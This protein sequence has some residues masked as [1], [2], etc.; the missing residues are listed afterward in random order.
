LRRLTD[1]GGHARIAGVSAPADPR[2]DGTARP[3]LRTCGGPRASEQALLGDLERRLAGPLEERLERPL[4]V[5]VPSRSL[6]VHLELRITS[7]LG[8]AVLGLSCRTLRHVAIDL[9]DRTEGTR[10]INDGLLP[11]L[12]RRFAR[13]QPVL[14]RAFEP[15]DDGYRTVAAAVRDLLE[16]GLEPALAEGL[17]EELAASGRAVAS[18]VELD[19]AHALLTV[20]AQVADELDRL[21]IADNST[22]LRRAAELVRGGAAALPRLSHLAIFGFADA[23]GT[24]TDLLEALVGRYDGTLYLDRPRDPAD[25]GRDDSGNSF[26]RRFSERMASVASPHG[27]SDPAAPPPPTVEMFRAVGAGSEVREVARRVRDLLAVGIAPEEICVVARRLEPYRFALREELDAL[28]V[29][30]S[31]FG[32]AGPLGPEGR[33]LYALLELLKRR[34]ATPIDHWLELQQGLGSELSRVLLRQALLCLGAGRLGEVATLRFEQL[35]QNGR[36]PLPVRQGFDELDGEEEAPARVLARRSSVTAGRLEKARDVARRITRRLA[37]LSGAGSRQALEDGLRQLVQRDLGWG[38]AGWEAARQLLDEAVELAGQGIAGG[39]PLELDEWIDLL[40]PVCEDAGALPIGGEGGGIQCLDVIEARSRTFGYLFLLGL[41]RGAFPR[42]VVEDPL[43]SDPLRHLLARSG[44]GLLP[45]LPEKRDGYAEERYLFA[46]LLDAAPHITLSWLD[47]DEEGARL[48]P[49]PLVERLRWRAGVDAPESWRETPSA[50]HRLAAATDGQGPRPVREATLLAGLRGDRRRFAELLPMA[51]VEGGAAG[52]VDPERASG[53]AAARLRLLAEVDPDLRTA[54]GRATRARLGPYLGAVGPPALGAADPRASGDRGISVTTLEAVS[55]CP[56]QAFLSK[57][58]R[59]EPSA[60]PL[61]LLPAIEGRLVGTLVHDVLESIVRPGAGPPGS[62]DQAL[63]RLPFGA[64]WPREVELARLVADAASRLVA[65]EGIA[66]PGFDRALAAVVGR[67]L[68]E[69]RRL[70]WADGGAP[71]VVAVEHWGAVLGESE[72]D[73]LA[74]LRFRADRVDRAGSETASGHP[75][76]GPAGTGAAGLCFTDYKTGRRPLADRPNRITTAVHDKIRSGEALQGAAYALARGNPADRG[77]YL[78]LHPELQGTDPPRA[79]ELRADD[80]ELQALFRS[81]VTA[82]VAAWDYG[83]FFPRLI[84]ADRDKEPELCSFCRVAEACVRGDSGAR[85]RLRDWA[86][87]RR[88]GA[89]GNAVTRPAGEES[90]LAA[91]QLDATPA[92][93]KRR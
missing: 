41:N 29:P 40:T 33:R 78:Y 61:E 63:A 90:W 86:D 59:L 52:G 4:L 10:P 5:V 80:P 76:T 25:R 65:R 36:Y 56:W 39:W 9:L 72:D 73:P 23:T 82:L 18:D 55:R 3:T 6:R 75:G 21:A 34:D 83:H 44:F 92:K 26:S 27:E 57:L 58:L 24:A 51:L 93:G 69:A 60:D 2:D 1:L 64:P 17:G 15:L 74:R 71:E 28:A 81:T 79:V 12:T 53:L 13:H 32:T 11:L 43:L 62:L 37:A 16:A 85:G 54:D 87:E 7:Q 50:P 42:V 68:D 8:P 19:R 14:R 46:Q 49:S 77:R 88:E 20:A 48:T 45:D 30:Y 70:D 67:H 89:A 22:L 84:H 35:L 66:L 38:A 91:W 47:A 31:A